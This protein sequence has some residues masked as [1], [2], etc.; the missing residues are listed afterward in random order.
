MTPAEFWLLTEYLSHTE[1]IG[2]KEWF[3]WII[4]A[5]Y[6]H[7]CEKLE[8]ASNYKG[9]YKYF[10]SIHIV[11]Y[12]NS[13]WKVYFYFRMYHVETCLIKKIPEFNFLPVGAEPIT[14]RL[15]HQVRRIIHIVVAYPPKSKSW[16]AKIHFGLKIQSFNFTSRSRKIFYKSKIFSLSVKSVKCID[17]KVVQYR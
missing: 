12:I 7:N 17:G 4:I 1:N 5:V 2:D 14:V 16:N 9:N 3:V 13:K 11:L 10:L 15:K 8:S 6:F